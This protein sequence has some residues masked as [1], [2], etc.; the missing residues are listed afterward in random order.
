MKYIALLCLLS[1]SA[2]A[3][4][5]L[6]QGSLN[7]AAMMLRQ[8]DASGAALGQAQLQI[9]DQGKVWQTKKAKYE[10]DNSAAIKETADYTAALNRHQAWGETLL[11]EIDRYNGQCSGTG[12]QSYV[13]QC[14]TWKG[15]L[16][17]LQV[18]FNQE[19]SQIDAWKGQLTPKISEVSQRHDSLQAEWN[20][21]SNAAA[22]NQRQGLAYL[23]KREQIIREMQQL[24]D[25]FNQRCAL[26]A[27]GGNKELASETCGEA[28][29]GNTVHAIHIPDV[30]SPQWRAWGA[31]AN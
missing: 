23:A 12:D 9:V 8:A 7:G 14:N 16:Q 6:V 22:E 10:A 4:D 18:R 3:D 25:G 26:A 1:I 21:M 20:Q 15:N 31:S 24:V 30:P 28:F 5:S 29:D 17:P 27:A 19:K 13:N 2:F 11:P